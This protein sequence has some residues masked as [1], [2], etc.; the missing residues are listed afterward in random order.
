LYMLPNPGRGGE[1]SVPNLIIN[2]ILIILLPVPPV[3]R[4]LVDGGL[5]FAFLALETFPETGRLGTA[6]DGCRY[7]SKVQNPSYLSSLGR[8][9]G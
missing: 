2:I 5:S 8:R 6:W 1:N 7:G 3:D 9:Y 4:G